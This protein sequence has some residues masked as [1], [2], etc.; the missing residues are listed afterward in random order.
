M[1]MS[2]YAAKRHELEV[3]LQQLND[4]E[5]EHKVELSVRYQ[6]ECRKIQTQIGSLKKKQKDLLQKYQQDKNYV[7]R[8]YRDDKLSITERMHTLRL[9]Y[10]TVNEIEDK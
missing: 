1:I 7:H 8:K 4:R 5:A 3:E 6:A 2:E 9:E 10:L